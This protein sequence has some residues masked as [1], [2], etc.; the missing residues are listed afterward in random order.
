MHLEDKFSSPP[1]GHLSNRVIL[2]AEQIKEKGLRSAAELPS[3]LQ[4]AETFAYDERE[5]LLTRALAHRAAANAEYL[6]NCFDRA[7]A[8]YNQ[9]VSMLEQVDNPAELARTLHAKVGLLYLLNRFDE[10]FECS[11]RARSIFEQL[12]DDRRLARLDVNLAHAYHRLDRHAEALACCERALPVLEE[13][14]D[15]EGLLAVLINKAVVLTVFH[16]FDQATDL[17]LKALARSKA[18]GKS[19]WAL[20]SRYNLA[21]MKYLSGAAGEALR[22]FS[23]LR[24]EFE[25][26]GDMR[27]VGLCRLDE[28]EVLLE[29]G[30]LDACILSAREARRVGRELGLNLEVGKS[31]FFEGVALMRAGRK[32]DAEPLLTDAKRCFES[33]TNNV[34]SAMLR[35]QTLLLSESE[36]VADSL[37]EAFANRQTLY[38]SGLAH[39]QAFSEV[40]IGRLERQSG[41]SLC[42]LESFERAVWLADNSKSEWMQF[43]A[44]YQLG[45]SLRLQD[46][47][48]AGTWLMK[49]ESKLDS[50]WQRL[51]QDDLKLAFL[52]DRENVYTHLV[53]DAVRDEPRKA[54]TLSEKARSRVLR[55]K[56]IDEAFD[57]SL[58]SI[59]GSLSPD[60][61]VL[62]YFIA[63]DDIFLFVVN[64]D[65]VRT[66]RLGS[67]ARLQE[68]CAHLEHHL[69]SCSVKW[70]M[71][72]SV[73]GQLEMT[74]KNHLAALYDRLIAPAQSEIRSNIVIVPHGFLH[75][76]PFHALFDGRH[77]LMEQHQIAYIPS[78]AL[79]CAP[80]VSF[81][82][83]APL[84]VAFNRD[85]H[86][87]SIREVETVASGFRGS[88]ILV[89]PSA[90]ALRRAF[91]HPRELIHIAG[92]AGI[93]SIGG[94]LSW[95]ETPEGR[96]D[97]RDLQDMRIQARTVVVTGCQTARRHIWPG[98][99]WLGLM[100]ALYMSGASA[101]VSAFWDVRAECAERFAIEFY[102]C[103]D[104]NNAA[105]AVR[106]ASAAIREQESHPYFWGGFGTFVRREAA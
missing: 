35:M 80:A 56:L 44:Y 61:T 66:I 84:F 103:F 8:H 104:G 27:H 38:K 30:D 67:P 13:V 54:F 17:Y 88:D 1:G 46:E 68:E 21:Y 37:R 74:A 20:L 58:D 40:V 5:D 47:E 53:A 65:S 52:G 48:T 43:H 31:L 7:L 72:T 75:S 33:E 50:L 51:E 100:R 32:A 2:L 14:R 85:A 73:R 71:L 18:Q 45:L 39:Y 64:H 76:V 29:I 97:S 57:C 96:L 60:E 70:E 79:Y 106:S 34:W 83:G 105:A 63:G 91:D 6:L 3:L 78:A 36:T 4:E 93:D 11:S 77:F 55:E 59:Q 86:A 9:S 25:L 26:A 42:A 41:N 89:N 95:I 98:D 16:E 24:H 49:A 69:E 22:Q 94:K 101:I 19:A 81:E 92:H 15:E 90:A 62:E 102:A 12:G 23:E 10:L 87:S 82:C 99:E 28:A